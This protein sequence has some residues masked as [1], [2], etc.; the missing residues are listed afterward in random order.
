MLIFN[1]FCEMPKFHYSLSVNF[2]IAKNTTKFSVLFLKILLQLNFNVFIWN[3]RK[4]LVNYKKEIHLTKK[5]VNPPSLHLIFNS[6]H[7]RKLH[8]KCTRIQF[9]TTSPS[10]PQSTTKSKETIKSR[11]FEK[12]KRENQWPDLDE[13]GS[14]S[15]IDCWIF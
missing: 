10:L 6:G 9:F 4:K 15:Q 7:W 14:T 5:T 8:F 13:I 11:V 2:R 12:H 1:N 3:Q